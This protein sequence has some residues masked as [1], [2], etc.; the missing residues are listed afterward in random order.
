MMSV[1]YLDFLQL[2]QPVEVRYWP[3]HG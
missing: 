1:G 3:I 2:N